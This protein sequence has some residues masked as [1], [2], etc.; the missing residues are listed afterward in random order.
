MRRKMR[1]EIY[2]LDG[3]E[4]TRKRW[5]G[6]VVQR[7]GDV[8]ASW[9]WDPGIFY[10]IAVFRVLMMMFWKALYWKFTFFFF[11]Y[12]TVY[13][14]PMSVFPLL[15][16]LPCVTLNSPVLYV[17]LPLRLLN[18]IALWCFLLRAY[19]AFELLLWMV[20]LNWMPSEIFVELDE[21]S[22]F[23]L[24]AVYLFVLP[25]D[26]LLRAFRLEMLWLWVW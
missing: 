21:L 12:A 10:L 4:R 18:F 13:L 25:S 14:L 16:L 23:F 1:K 26:V 22:L 24:N 20:A 2:Y 19:V 5:G 17:C 9:L 3:E 11:F 15:L 7:P 6:S 8:R